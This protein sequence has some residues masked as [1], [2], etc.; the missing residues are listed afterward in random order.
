MHD[1]EF[2]EADSVGKLGTDGTGGNAMKFSSPQ[3]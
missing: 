3:A 2:G 1:P